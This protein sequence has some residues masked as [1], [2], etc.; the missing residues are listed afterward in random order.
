[1]MRV[2]MFA[3]KVALQVLVLQGPVMLLAT[4]AIGKTVANTTMNYFL[5]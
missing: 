2:S 3:R 1:M 4:T 5:L